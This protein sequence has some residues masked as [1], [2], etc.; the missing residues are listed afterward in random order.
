MGINPEDQVE[1][2]KKAERN[3][4][5]GAESFSLITY[6]FSLFLKNAWEWFL[7]ALFPP[8]CLVCRREGAYLCEKHNRFL[9]AP[10]SEAE[11]HFLDDIHAATKYFS[12][13][14][15]QCVEFFKFKGGRHLGKIFATEMVKTT[16]RKL[17]EGGVLVP[18]PLH[19]TRKFWRGFNQAEVLAR[20]ISRMTGLPLSTNLQRQK[21][22]RQQARLSRSDR[23]RNIHGIF[24]W[25][26]KEIPPK[27]ILVDDVVA[28][29]ATLDEAAKILKESGCQEVVAV[30][31]AR[32]GKNR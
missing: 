3:G 7:E 23:S 17:L 28:S 21:Y 32:G 30:V 5:Y 15:E 19:W 1:K 12:S 8:R 11:F 16:P 20:E 24:R 29:G 18:I 27:I 26:G 6:Y 4:E 9:P 10:P 2:K 31:F 13:P 22:T 14:S 25:R